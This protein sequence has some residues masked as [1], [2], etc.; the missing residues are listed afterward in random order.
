MSVM[1]NNMACKF[2]LFSFNYIIIEPTDTFFDTTYCYNIIN[3]IWYCNYIVK[4]MNF[5]SPSDCYHFLIGN[6]LVGLCAET[7]NLV[8]C[9]DVLSRMCSCDPLSAKQ[10]KMNQCKQN[11]IAFASRASNF[12]S[13]LLSKTNNNRITFYL[14]GQILVTITR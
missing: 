8:A 6:G 13:I 7:Q 4:N 9:M 11:Y 14:N 3:I 2:F 5:N 1:F 10:A 12:T